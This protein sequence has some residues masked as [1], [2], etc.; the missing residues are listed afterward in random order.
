MWQSY[1]DEFWLVQP[2]DCP[3]LINVIDP[4]L[5]H[6]LESY[7]CQKLVTVHR[8]CYSL[9]THKV[10]STPSPCSGT[11]ASPQTVLAS[12][13]AK[14]S[15]RLPYHWHSGSL[16]LS[17]K[18]VLP[19]L[20]QVKTVRRAWIEGPNKS[21][22]TRMISVTLESIKTKYHRTL[23]NSLAFRCCLWMYGL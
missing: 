21:I 19:S 12:F 1:V 4:I 11:S 16:L 20:K 23:H 14:S 10:G 6:P 5:N 9:N 3:L 8:N 22:F 18:V 7:N 13:P 15:P 17:S 2:L